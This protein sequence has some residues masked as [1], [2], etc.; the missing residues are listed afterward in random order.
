MSPRRALDALSVY[1]RVYR[2]WY[3]LDSPAAAVP[4]L[5]LV[6]I[7][8]NY[9][10][11]TLGDGTTVP[12]FGRIG[13]LHLNNE[14]VAALHAGRPSPLAVGFEFRRQFLASLET[15]ARLSAPGGRL[16]GVCAFTAV[17]I[18]HHALVRAGFGIEPG[19]LVWRA[20][21]GAYQRALLASLHPSGNSRLVGLGAARAERL[22]ITRE[23]LLTRYGPEPAGWRAERD[24]GAARVGR[25][26]REP[27]QAPGRRLIGRR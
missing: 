4:P 24:A 19:G 14:R 25:P 6:E 20:S 26:G 8:R 12:R 23:E 9:R 16:A 7:R 13:V 18:F 3:R 21:A 22:W 17:T 1:D 10:W 2:F 5:L 27:A 15:L 11:R